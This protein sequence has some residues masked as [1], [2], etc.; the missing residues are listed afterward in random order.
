MDEVQLD[1]E[2]GTPPCPE[3]YWGR[4]YRALEALFEKHGLPGRDEAEYLDAVWR[5]WR[6]ARA[7]KGKDI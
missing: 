1:L 3:E 4:R 2:F 6:T 5:S 7:V